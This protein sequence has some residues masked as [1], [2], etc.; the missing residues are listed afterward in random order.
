[1]HHTDRIGM[2]KRWCS[3]LTSE[4]LSPGTWD[5]VIGI[6]QEEES[7]RVVK[8]LLL[9]ARRAQRKPSE[10]GNKDSL[11]FCEREKILAQMSPVVIWS[12]SIAWVWIQ[13][14]C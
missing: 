1:M 3:G 10:A 7:R 5:I 2:F 11:L 4:G 14:G 6:W 13:G 9:E 12:C 8:R